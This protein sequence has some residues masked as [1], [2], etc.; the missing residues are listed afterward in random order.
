MFPKLTWWEDFCHDGGF[1][2]FFYFENWLLSEQLLT[3][4]GKP[5]GGCWIV[6]VF[7][8][9]TK[10]NLMCHGHADGQ[11]RTTGGMAVCRING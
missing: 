9:N 3:E 7:Q 5:Q 11:E 4:L 1:R 10:V 2:G 8:G 6:W